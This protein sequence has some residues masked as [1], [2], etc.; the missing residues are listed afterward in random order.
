MQNQMQAPAKTHSKLKKKSPRGKKRK[1]SLG[2]DKMMSLQSEV[3]EEMAKVASDVQVNV[4]TADENVIVLD[5][6]SPENKQKKTVT[7]KSKIPPLVLKPPTKEQTPL[8]ARGKK[9]LKSEQE[10]KDKKKN[11]EK[12]KGKNSA[13]EAQIRPSRRAATKAKR[14]FQDMTDSDDSDVTEVEVDSDNRGEGSKSKV[15]KSG[16]KKT[17]KPKL[18][19][20]G[21]GKSSSYFHS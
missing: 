13:E 5:G 18:K 6:D 14:I 19:P 16:E 8:K 10:K 15:N 7:K 1:L 12:L 3:I 4:A 20:S 2:K 17:E 11:S 9:K 21:K